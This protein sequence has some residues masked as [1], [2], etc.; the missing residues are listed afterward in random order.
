MARAA[1]LRASDP[2]RANALWA[3]A[4]RMVVDRAAAV[5]LV[6]QHVVG[7]VSERVGNYQLH[8]QWLTLLDQ[9]WVR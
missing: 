5:P 1:D 8:P 7:F 4:D 2:A 9:L 6:N 3:E